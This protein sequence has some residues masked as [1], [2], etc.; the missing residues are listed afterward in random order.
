RGWGQRGVARVDRGEELREAFEGAMAQSTSAGL[1]IVVVESWLEGGEYSVNGWIENG[2]LVNYCVTERL[3]VP[4]KK[5]LGVMLAEVYPSG[6][7]PADEARV[8]DEARRGAKAL[9]HLR[10]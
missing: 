1:A 7:S 8:V 6:L 5:P 3:T 4:G 2:S 9:G 10:G